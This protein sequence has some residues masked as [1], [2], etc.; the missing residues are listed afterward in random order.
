V[1]AIH[2]L[3]TL[4]GLGLLDLNSHSDESFAALKTALSHP[5]AG[6]RRNALMVLPHSEQGFEL[7]MSEAQLFKDSEVQVRLQ[8]ILT[9]ADMPAQDSAGLQIAKLSEM[10][11]DT[12]LIDALTSA[13]ATHA[14]P[15]LRAVMQGLADP[16]N[17]QLQITRRI[18]EHVARGRPD[19]AGLVSL[20][21]SIPTS[22]PAIAD[23]VLEGLTRGLPSD[24]KLD[25]SEEFETVL[26]AAFQNT[27]NA[28]KFKLLRLAG[29]CKSTA[30]EPFEQEIVSL[31]TK[32]LSDTS[33]DADQRVTAAANLINFR[34]KDDAAIQ[35]VMNQINAQTPPELA[36]RLL[37]T[38]RASESES[39]AD[40]I[41]KS[42]RFLTPQSKTSALNVLLSKPVWTKVL[43]ETAEKKEFDLNELSLEQ[44]QSLRTS[45]NRQLRALAE[46]LLAMGG[47]LPNA[48]REK[49]I[50][51]LLHVTKVT[52][53]VDAGKEVFRETCAACHVHGELGKPIGPELTGMAVHPKEELL[54][55]ILDPSRN[56]EGNFRLY[57][58]LTIDGIVVNG[59]LAGETRTTITIIDSLG[60]E[61]SIPRDEIEELSASQ[62][63]VM[64]EGYEKQLSE[65]QLADLL[66]FL[67]AKD[68]F[69]PISLDRYATAISTKPLFTEQPNGPDQMIF[70]DWKPKT[71]D[72]VPFILTDPRGQ[73]TPN[74]IMLYGP[75]GPLP[76]KMP[77]SVTLPC[78][79][80]AKKIHLLSG[81]GGWSHPFDQRQSVSMIVR[82][83]YED[84]Q[85]E[86]HE[87]LNGVHFAD[88]IARNDVPGSQ[89]A[90]RLRGQQLRYLFIEPKRDATIKSIDLVKGND[91]TA[92]LVM[93][94]TVE[95]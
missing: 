64:P 67:T 40:L 4:A 27:D 60:K 93:A 36:S 54:T 71:F 18:A 72:G 73:T 49:V 85:S 66:E 23:V 77:R 22:R 35:L 3:Q 24:F 11:T 80:A 74:I 75:C 42:L 10:E 9:L 95:R 57:N 81:V 20:V 14:V 25:S 26:I 63:S 62:K 76:P 89:F 48:D 52:G 68:R 29:Q 91:G 39:A 38:M 56:V 21:E 86:D 6:V 7:L 51:D 43:L 15:Y 13:A 88:Y 19:G 44:Q 90:F 58:V 31:L 5:S 1:G 16:S 46:K 50:H 8:A 87:L 37:E 2:G 55:H 47:G 94:V 33:S 41:L 59:M 78:N 92:P 83:H 28:G 34:S 12:I 17:A 79:T 84:G 61:I 32:A 70:D 53:K 45:P 82:L 65:T 30:L 69:L